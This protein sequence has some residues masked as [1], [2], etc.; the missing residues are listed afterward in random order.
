MSNPLSYEQ[1]AMFMT[2]HEIKQNYSVHPGEKDDDETDEQLYKRKARE[3]HQREFTRLPPNKQ[4][5]ERVVSLAEGIRREGVKRP[6]ELSSADKTV[7]DGH[8]RLSVADPHK[9]I[10]VTHLEPEEMYWRHG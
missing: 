2:P 8:H 6:V 3:S 4:G 10:P 1:L 7:A 5:M 9:L